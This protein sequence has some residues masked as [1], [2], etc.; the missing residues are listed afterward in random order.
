MA[1]FQSSEQLYTALR[2]VFAQLAAEPEIIEPFTHSNLVI[3]MR[4]H[5]PDAEVLLDGRQPP[6]EV[7][8]GPRPGSADLEVGL[9]AD[10]LHAIW[11]GR[12]DLAQSIFGGQVKIQG[13]LLRA[14]HFTTLMQV[15]A[16][17]YPQVW[18][19]IDG[20]AA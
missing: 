4:L 13:K 11:L 16:Q 19:R 20:H 3:R 2:A 15:C 14:N 17:F 18:A 8:Y 7:F 5:N 12:A 1:I 10:L 9:S 6:F